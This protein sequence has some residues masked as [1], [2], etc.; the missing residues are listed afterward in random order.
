ME[1]EELKQDEI[2]QEAPAKE[3]KKKKVN[4][5]EELERRLPKR[6]KAPANGMQ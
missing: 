4:R 3:E 2:V 6:K 1:K 5:K